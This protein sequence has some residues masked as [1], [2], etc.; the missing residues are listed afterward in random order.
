[1]REIAA[2]CV[3]GF[4]DEGKK[5]E[6]RKSGARMKREIAERMNQKFARER[7]RERERES[8]GESKERERERE[9]RR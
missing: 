1:L 9:R 2:N 3:A 5:A 6:E 4:A 8:E 7:E